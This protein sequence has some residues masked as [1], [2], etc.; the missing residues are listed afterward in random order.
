[1]SQSGKHLVE[2]DKKS[3][4]M[5]ELENLDLDLREARAWRARIRG[6]DVHVFD[7]NKITI[8]S[9]FDEAVRAALGF[10][11]KLFEKETI[12]DGNHR[13]KG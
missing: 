4:R 10:R 11:D 13:R 2:A 9:H 1:M 12:H 6:P 3:K 8:L 7:C 5:M